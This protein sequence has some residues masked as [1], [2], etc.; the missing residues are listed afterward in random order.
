MQVAFDDYVW[1][2]GLATDLANTSPTV[3]HGVDQLPDVAALQAFL[4]EHGLAGRGLVLR[5]VDPADL[6]PVQA[7]R[8]RLRPVIEE[9]DP[10]RRV[11]AAGALTG[12]VGGVTLAD[13]WAVT[14]PDDASPAE[15]LGVVA[16]VG[17]LAV[18]LH[19]GA[20]RCRACSSD[21]CSGVFIDTSR[22]GRRRYCMPGHCGN[23]AN[24][25]AHRA[26]RR[27]AGLG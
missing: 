5:A 15:V 18:Q 7:L 14:V 21:T 3:W 13:G 4:D 24:V 16:G 11:A 20:E 2:A 25:A 10:A 19:L 8:D 9:Q 6:A 17:I 23:R 1:S 22:P 12:A 27:A 26:R